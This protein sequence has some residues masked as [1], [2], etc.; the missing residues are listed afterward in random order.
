MT[1]LDIKTSWKR[2][3]SNQKWKDI[4]LHSEDQE[5]GPAAIEDMTINPVI[6]S[7]DVCPKIEL[8]E[9]YFK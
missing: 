2:I 9:I 5:A 4:F 1:T 7:V 8:M 6:C 3:Q